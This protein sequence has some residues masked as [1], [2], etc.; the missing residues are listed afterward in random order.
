[1]KRKC[2]SFEYKI[3]SVSKT[4]GKMFGIHFLIFSVAS[5][6]LVLVSAQIFCSDLLAPNKTKYYPVRHCQRSNKTRIAAKNVENLRKCEQFAE[7]NNGLAFNYG[8]GRKPRKKDDS[9]NWMNLF[10]II[11]K[12][13]NLT[14]KWKVIA[15]E[16]ELSNDP[17]FN[18]EIFDCPEVGNMSSIINDTRYDYYSIYGRG[19]MRL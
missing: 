16:L 10:D 6:H 17:Y 13:E 2:Q 1:M 18:C 12:E 3:E 14:N 19:K 9:N 7:Y 8:H 5:S 4:H 11:K 15:K